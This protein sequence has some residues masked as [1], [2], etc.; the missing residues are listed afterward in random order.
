MEWFGNHVMKHNT[1][2]YCSSSNYQAKYVI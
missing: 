2:T 1:S